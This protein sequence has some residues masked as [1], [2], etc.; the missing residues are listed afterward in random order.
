MVESETDGTASIRF[1]DDVYGRRPE[2]R[3]SFTAEYRVGNGRPGNIGADT[4]T[5]IVSGESAITAVRNPLP[6]QGGVDSESIEDVRQRAPSAFRT[7]QRAVT[8]EDYAE[9]TERKTQVVQRAAG[10]FR[11]TGSWHTVFITV[12]RLGTSASLPNR[13]PKIS[14]PTWPICSSNG[15]C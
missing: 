9:V 2:P 3:T 13:L 14:R 7:Q 11:W 15:N 6:A 4:L 12:D 5:H 8:E 1:G 10:T